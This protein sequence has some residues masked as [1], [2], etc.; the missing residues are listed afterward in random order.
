MGRGDLDGDRV[1]DLLHRNYD[2]ENYG[3]SNAAG[4][5]FSSL[6]SLLASTKAL[7]RLY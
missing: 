4:S 7:L 5:E 6:S 1:V 3:E 2:K